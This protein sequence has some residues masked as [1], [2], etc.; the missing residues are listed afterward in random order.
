MIIAIL[1]RG[2][3]GAKSIAG[4]IQ[5]SEGFF[6][7]IPLFILICVI[8]GVANSLYTYKLHKWHVAEGYR[9]QPHD[10]QWTPKKLTMFMILAIGAGVASG[11]LGAGG[12][13][14]MGPMLIMLGV[15]PQINSATSSFLVFFT[16]SIAALT[17]TLSGRI[18]EDYG[19]FML[20]ISFMA[21]IV[22]ILSIRWIINRYKRPSAITALMSLA[23]FNDLCE[24]F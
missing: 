17:F 3:M 20:V 13:T 8:I 18:P 10:M 9:F 21:G 7:W 23:K 15:H 12:G 2:G 19:L 11:T 4:I 14:P 22:G 5:C 6:A 1:I 24:G 16:A